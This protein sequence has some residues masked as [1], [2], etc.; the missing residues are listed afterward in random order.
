[1]MVQESFSP[2]T[3]FFILGV[4]HRDEEG[5]QLLREWMERAKPD[6]VTLEF[7]NYGLTFRKERGAEL[8]MM[9][10]KVLEALRDDNEPYKKEAPSALFSYVDMPHEYEVATK[11]CNERNIPLYLIDMDVFSYLKLQK[12]DDLLSEEN[13]KKLLCEKEG[14]DNH[15]EKT[16]A[17]MFFEKGIE[18]VSYTD[19]MYVRDKYMSDRI[20][21][22]MKYHKDKRFL[23]VCG[24]QHLQ[25]P[26]NLYSSLNPIKVF[27]YD[28]TICL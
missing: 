4:I 27:S 3:K 24:W 12:V 26:H 28:K 20:A 21:I 2:N 5:P 9:I 1:M 14:N 25:D 22:L 18:V 19:E 7:S 13:I 8:K 15:N 6:V 16:L 11:Y 17:K 23:H 10:D